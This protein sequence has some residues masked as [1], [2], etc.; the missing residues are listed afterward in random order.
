MPAQQKRGPSAQT[1]IMHRAGYVTAAEAANAIGVTNV[2]T[3]HRMLQAKKIAGKRVGYFWFV[4]GQA[5]YDAYK[6]TPIERTVRE[7]LTACKIRVKNGRS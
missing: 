7:L 1:D 6:D 4:E 3:V 2:G 5:L